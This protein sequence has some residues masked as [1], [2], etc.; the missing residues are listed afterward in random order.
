MSPTKRIVLNI[1]ATYGRSLYALGLG[2]FTGRW[3]LMALGQVDY[4]LYGVVGGLTVFLA[5]FNGL[6][7]GAISRFYAFEIG[8]SN[9]A[10]DQAAALEECRKW[11]NTALLMHTFVPVVC[12]AVG[13]P[14]GIWAIQEFLEIPPDRVYACTWVFR[15]VCISSFVS[16][17]NVPFQAMYTAKQY[18]AELTIY[19]VA[20]STLQALFLY[21]IASHPSDWL[22][23]YSAWTC[24]IAV[25]PQIIIC[26]RAWWVFPEC[27]VR[28]QYFWSGDRVRKIVSFA[29][30]HAFG[31]L[32]AMLRGQGMAILVNKYFG[33]RVNA[34]MSVANTVNGQST[35]LVAAMQGAFTPA[36]VQA[37]GAG[38]ERRMREMAYRACKFGLLFAIVFILPLG[39]EIDNV[40]T[41]WLKIPPHY[42]AGLC[43][44]MLVQVLFDKSTIGHLIAVD[45]KGK[46]A[47]YQFVLG[48]L[49]IITLPLAWLLV[50]LGIGVYSIGYALVIMMVISALGR[51]W[52]A[53]TLTGMSIRYW[54]LRILIPVFISMVI[55]AAIAWI[56]RLFMPASFVRLCLTAIVAEIVF[57]PLAWFLVLDIEERQFAIQKIKEF[58]Y[59]WSDL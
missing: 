54:F 26:L 19:G 12:L 46:I 10:K 44:C 53:R 1:I 39:I 5:F 21:Y 2:L 59:K 9:I 25:A 22:I 47:A 48:G 40:M 17:V 14:L 15:F 18:I 51:V 37:C 38:D 35:S 42:A 30:W 29:G 52:F 49:L 7:S 28:P 36:I 27:H 4:G 55:A 3:V 34:A 58:K 16:M 33:A 6:L 41:L 8:K 23:R 57:S 24:F 56:P 11:F 43:L 20:T 31:A 32:G 13:Y 50:A 45:A